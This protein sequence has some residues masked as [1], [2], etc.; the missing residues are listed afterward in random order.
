MFSY[1]SKEDF[2]YFVMLAFKQ[3]KLDPHEIPLRLSGFIKQESEID[4][5]LKRYI[6]NVEYG[7]QTPV[8]NNHESSLV[9]EFDNLKAAPFCV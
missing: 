9:Y 4:Q 2:V 8:S 6:K 7:D 5:L 1:Q 3:L